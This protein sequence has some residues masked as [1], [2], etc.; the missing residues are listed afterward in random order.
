M[1]MRNKPVRLLR[2]DRIVATSQLNSLRRFKDDVPE[3]ASGTECGIGVM[4]FK[5]I[6]VGDVIEV[7]E[8]VAVAREL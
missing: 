8:E 4:D 2:D 1:V 6:Q 7:Y 5:D 3:V